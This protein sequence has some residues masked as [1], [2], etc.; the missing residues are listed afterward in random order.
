MPCRSLA[1]ERHLHRRMAAEGSDGRTAR[2]P[3]SAA[4]TRHRGH[5]APSRPGGLGRVD[6]KVA[7][8]IIRLG[9]GV[10]EDREA[11]RNVAEAIRRNV[12]FATYHY[13]MPTI[14]AVAQ[15][16]F[17]ASWRG[18]RPGRRIAADLEETGG[19]ATCSEGSYRHVHGERCHLE[20]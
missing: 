2:P 11:R 16:E 1:S 9:Y 15:A 14:D 19:G 12:P 3:P 6:G 10:T 7:A 5:F 17:T 18:D 13:F 20:R 4:V 8:V